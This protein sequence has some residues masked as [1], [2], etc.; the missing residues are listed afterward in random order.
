MSILLRWDGYGTATNMTFL[1]GATGR[2]DINAMNAEQSSFQNPFAVGFPSGGNIIYGAATTI[3]SRTNVP[4]LQVRDYAVGITRPFMGFDYSKAYSGAPSSALST[5]SLRYYFHYPATH[6]ANIGTIGF[7]A[8]SGGLHWYGL[9]LEANTGKALIPGLTGSTGSSLVNQWIRVEIQVNS[10]FSPKIDVRWYAGDSTTLLGRISPNPA[11]LTASPQLIIGDVVAGGGVN[12][13]LSLANIEFCDTYDLDGKFP[14]GT[15]SVSTVTN[16]AGTGTPVTAYTFPSDLADGVTVPTASFTTYTDVSYASNYTRNYTLYVP[17]GTPANANGFP[18]VMWSHGGFFVSGNKNL[19]PA[20]W[21][22]TLLN[23][24]YAVATIRYLKSS[25]DTSG[26]YDAWGTNDPLDSN[27]PA[28]GRY[29]SWII[30][31]KL[32]AVRIAAKCSLASGGDNTYAK[33]DGSRMFAT[34]Y[35][36]GGYIALGAAVS[37]GLTND[38]ST[39]DLTIAGNSTYRDG[40]TGADPTFI[41]SFV[42][43]APID[44]AVACAW[45]PTDFGYGPI[46]NASSRGTVVAAAQAFIGQSQNGSIPTLTNTNIDNLIARNVAQNTAAAIPRI[47]YS[48]GTGDYLVHWAH[49]PLLSAAMTTAGISSKYFSYSAPTF[50]DNLNTEFRSTDVVGFL[51]AA[52]AASGGSTGF[53]TWTPKAIVT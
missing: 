10:T 31:Y 29:P 2:T 14:G 52:T 40:Y 15:A 28:F 21:R 30:D 24:G 32:A 25:A 17:N 36:A 22:N 45:D 43:G 38:G 35:S 41:G 8:G 7:W 20:N 51:N 11:S 50:H 46:I 49:E 44:M 48:R 13:T 19:L 4:V 34:G 9:C 47:G 27:T 6:F 42:Y 12:P 39:R 33:V 37:N 16:S 23:A 53:A 1:P 18:L 3:N 26:G 5:Y